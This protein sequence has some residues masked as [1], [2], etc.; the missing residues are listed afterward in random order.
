M[1]GSLVVL[2]PPPEFN[3]SGKIKSVINQDFDAI[4]PIPIFGQIK[5]MV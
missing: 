2:K 5:E 4:D 1:M 3:T